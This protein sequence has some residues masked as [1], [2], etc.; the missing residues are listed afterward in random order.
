MCSL[1]LY[2]LLHDDHF[3]NKS[4]KILQFE[5]ESRLPYSA[6]LPTKIINYSL[7]NAVDSSMTSSGDDC[8]AELWIRVGNLA[9]SRPIGENS[10]VFRSGLAAHISFGLF[11]L[12]L[13]NWAY[14]PCGSRYRNS[15]I[16]CTS[17]STLP[18]PTVEIIRF[19]IPK[20]ENWNTVV[21]YA[22]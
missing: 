20:P 9:F 15:N 14:F 19:N 12:F 2:L 22:W 10:V 3:L 16:M 17:W 7:I 18:F 1:F 8:A 13:K 6:T 21:N 5:F 11:W 4:R